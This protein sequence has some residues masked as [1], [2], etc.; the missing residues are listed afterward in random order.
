MKKL[1]VFS[2]LNDGRKF[3]WT[4]L[5]QIQNSSMQMYSSHNIIR[6]QNAENYMS[7]KTLETSI[8]TIQLVIKHH[9]KLVLLESHLQL[10]YQGIYVI[11]QIKLQ[12]WST[13]FMCFEKCC[14]DCLPKPNRLEGLAGISCIL[15]RELLCAILSPLRKFP[16]V[17]QVPRKENI[18]CS[19][20]YGYEN[21]WHFA[22]NYCATSLK[23]SLKYFNK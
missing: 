11:K 15:L 2:N 13:Q 22:T 12:T 6:L 19:S 9:Q 3:S 8:K 1:G 4:F 20:D 17:S 16:L 14:F 10:T 23:V 5:P 21:S 7:F 18:L